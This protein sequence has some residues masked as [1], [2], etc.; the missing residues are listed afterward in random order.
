MRRLF[1]MSV[2]VAFVGAS[3]VGSNGNTRTVLVDFQHEQFASY[4]TQY[5][6]NQ[7]A[8][9]PGD[10]V[11]F[12]QTWTGEP[13]SVTMG[14][15][16][17]QFAKMIKPYLAAFAKGGYAAVPGDEPPPIKAFDE[18][19]LTNMFDPQSNK[20]AQNGAQPCFLSR[21]RAPRNIN[22]PCS[23]AHQKQPA[24]TGRQTYYNSGFIH[25]D[26][27]TGDTY[28]VKISANAKPGTH[29]FYCNYHGPFMSGFLTIEP[30][31][32]TIPSQT[33]VNARARREI[34]KPAALLLNAF[35]SAEAGRFVPPPQAIPD[36]EQNGLTKSSNGKTYFNGWFAGLGADKVD[37]AAI[38]EFIPKNLTAKV[39]EKLTW[40]MVGRHTLSFNPP[41]YFPVM[42]VL[43]NG[44][45]RI[46]PKLD[47]PHGGAPNPPGQSNNDQS[48]LIDDAGTWNGRGF[49]STGVIE[50]NNFAIISLRITRPGTY[51]FACLIHPPMIGTL[52]V[53]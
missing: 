4:F 12:R 39:G 37:T 48:A 52:V 50:P 24:F 14:T 31:N 44:T 51:K 10:S 16:A 20:V 17:D 19:Y 42:Q 35:Q 32:R 25:Y 11:I 36:L 53:R 22:K 18:K 47:P 6:P 34:D 15:Y 1:A 40:V 43:K 45:V 49:W 5:F 9:H 30:K 29:F 41:K 21:G 46:N 23:K 27:P 7:V 8:V 33:T 28:T 38:N 2:I 13:H 26:G 3:C